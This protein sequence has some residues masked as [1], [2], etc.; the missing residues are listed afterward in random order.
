MHMSQLQMRQPN[1]T[2]PRSACAPHTSQVQSAEGASALLKPWLRGQPPSSEGPGP[3]ART[4]AKTSTASMGADLPLTAPA[5]PAEKALATFT[6][7]TLPPPRPLPRRPPRPPP[8]RPR[9]LPR[10]ETPRPRRFGVPVA[11]GQDVAGNEGW[12]ASNMHGERCCDCVNLVSEAALAPATA[13]APAS[14]QS[15]VTSIASVTPR[16]NA[17]QT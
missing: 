4:A 7:G 2:S 3:A 12:I 9:P 13:L 8:L 17:C 5:T 10:P 6:E 1:S 11:A 14:A 15:S 16:G